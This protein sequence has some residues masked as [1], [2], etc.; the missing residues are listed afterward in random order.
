MNS[1]QYQSQYNLTTIRYI[2]I[3]YYIYANVTGRGVPRKCMDYRNFPHL[4][5]QSCKVGPPVLS[6][7]INLKPHSIPHRPANSQTFF[8]SDVNNFYPLKTTMKSN[9]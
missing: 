3:L 7:S 1:L 2:Y 6:W 4:M 5:S 9:K 8:P